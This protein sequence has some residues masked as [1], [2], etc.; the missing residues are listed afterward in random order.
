MDSTVRSLQPELTPEI[1][2]Q[3]QPLELPKVAVR[4]KEKVALSKFEKLMFGVVACATVALMM[5]LVHTTINVSSSQRQLQDVQSKITKVETTNVDL[6][7]EVGEL[8]SSDR[9]ATYA[10]ENGLTFNDANV[11]NVTQ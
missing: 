8:T 11:R 3:A 1:V 2:P 5:M 10:K 7:Q 9:L 4:G 6:Q